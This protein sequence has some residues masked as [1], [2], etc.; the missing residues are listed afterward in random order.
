MALRLLS[1]IASGRRSD[2][3]RLRRVADWRGTGWRPIDFARTATR[4]GINRSAVRTSRP[5][6]TDLLG[7]AQTEA[8]PV[9]DVCGGAE[10]SE[11]GY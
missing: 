5:D 8:R 6:R 9:M 7:Q 10:W 11:M 4:Q 1:G 3:G 2:A